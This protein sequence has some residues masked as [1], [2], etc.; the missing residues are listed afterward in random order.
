METDKEAKPSA[1]QIRR[2]IRNQRMRNIQYIPPNTRATGKFKAK[3][4]AERS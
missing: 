3:E 2:E 4:R 1:A